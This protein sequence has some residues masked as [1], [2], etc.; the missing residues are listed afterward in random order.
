MCIVYRSSYKLKSDI[1][2]SKH[3][4]TRSARIK[5]NIKCS[6]HPKVKFHYEMKG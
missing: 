1:M 2:V 3:Q 5:I 6:F 4:S